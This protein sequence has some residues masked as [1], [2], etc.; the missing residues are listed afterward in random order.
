MSEEAPTL[1]PSSQEVWQ[2]AQAINAV[3]G[4]ASR[5][6][7][8]RERDG[9]LAHSDDEHAAL[10]HEV[11]Q[12]PPVRLMSDDEQLE[13]HRRVP[14]ALAAQHGDEP[15]S[16]WTARMVDAQGKPTG[17]W[18]VEAHT[19]GERGGAS[20]TA[21]VVCR[22]AEDA[23]AMARHLREYGTAEDLGRLHE[24]TARGNGQ[25]IE[26][27][28]PA[29]QPGAAAQLGRHAAPLVLSEDAWEAAL[30]RELSPGLADRIIVKDPAHR[31]HSAW[32]ELHALANHEVLVGGADPA[33]LA[34][35][36]RVVPHW[37]DDVLNPPALAHWAIKESRTSPRYDRI[38]AGPAAGAAVQGSAAASSPAAEDRAAR[39][40]RLT[41]VRSPRD[42]VEWAKGLD[43]RNPAHR[44]EAK[45]GFGHWGD[46]VDG[47][48]NSKFPGLVQ[49]AIETA[50]K[51]RAKQNAKAA[52]AEQVGVAEVEVAVAEPAVAEPAADPATLQ[53]LADRVDRLD[54]ARPIHRREAHIMLGRVPADIDRL[55]AEKFSDDPK[56]VEKVQALYPDGLPEANAA[57]WRNRAQGDEAVAVAEAAVADDPTT[58]RREDVDAEVASQG[59]RGLATA[60]R[61][62][63]NT[64]A[65]TQPDVLRRTA[66][67]QP[68]PPVRRRT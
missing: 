30:R 57:A 27:P 68:G 13:W 48:L 14:S 7:A 41:E 47:V 53:E 51:E 29:Q 45:A 32:R 6:R 9:R 11:R 61:G 50:K 62:I 16:V 63:A 22:D 38:V 28:Q 21:M 56:I 54:P 37:R 43:A 35:I 67:Q 52:S 24:L 42:A 60:Q 15:I 65:G 23:L 19:W 55:I 40:P 64:V 66:Q 34:A 20:A 59:E 4:L 2:W 1:L 5:I 8:R 31:H 18:G 26:P 10:Q 12:H 44:L 36:V 3:S 17:E 46:E 39:P 33:R 25:F 49:K 58:P